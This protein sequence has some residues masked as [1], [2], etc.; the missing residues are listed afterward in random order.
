MGV[1]LLI[2]MLTTIEI[3]WQNVSE[4]SGELSLLTAIG[5]RSGNI[6]LMILLEGIVCGML[7]GVIGLVLAISMMW[8]MYREF[9]SEYMGFILMTGIIPVITGL[10]GAIL[11][12]E[13]AV[14]INPSR[15][16]TGQYTNKKSAD[17][18]VKWVLA[19]SVISL[20][21]GLLFVM[22]KAAP[23]LEKKSEVVAVSKETVTPTKG[24]TTKGSQGSKNPK[25]VE[26]KSV[27]NEEYDAT[28]SLGNDLSWNV[29]S[30]KV[31]KINK[32]PNEINI[33]EPENGKKQLYYQIT[34][35]NKDMQVYEFRPNLNFKLQTAHNSVSP[36]EAVNIKSKGLDNRY[37]SA[38]GSVSNLLIFEIPKSEQEQSLLFKSRNFRKGILVNLK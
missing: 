3:M 9:P 27:T 2:A 17:K 28:I 24:K 37:L 1:A 13:K 19:V 38:K 23:Q 25:E 20:F 15:G 10:L 34:L 12:A 21:G 8:G 33:K 4:R 16:I 36:V 7:A 32:L 22:I 14:R 6:R 31:E 35:K 30:F 5:W 26:D 18:K 29:L 11:P